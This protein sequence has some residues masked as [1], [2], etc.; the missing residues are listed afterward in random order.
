ME[1][2]LIDISLY[3]KIDLKYWYNIIDIMVIFTVYTVLFI[4]VFN[5]L[6]SKNIF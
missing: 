4:T 2:F 6:S 3:I 5:R 1:C